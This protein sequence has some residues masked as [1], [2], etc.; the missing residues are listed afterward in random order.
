MV[1]I[2][3]GDHS[4]QRITLFT[5][6]KRVSLDWINNPRKIEGHPIAQL[7]RLATRESVLWGNVR[8]QR[9]SPSNMHTPMV[10]RE[11]RYLSLLG[12]QWE[13]Y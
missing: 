6:V 13:Y 3:M 2:P 9:L 7:Y 4:R 5:Y 12:G 8:P 11:Y 10:I 1:R